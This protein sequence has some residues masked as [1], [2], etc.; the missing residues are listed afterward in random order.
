MRVVVVGATG[1]VGTSVLESLEGESGVQ[2]IAA[3][4]RRDPERTFAHTRF[5]PPDVASWDLVSIFRGADAVVYLA[6]LIQPSRDE[7]STYRVK[8]RRQ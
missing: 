5:E 3:V 1:N 7:A 8:C 4:A 2:E 6:W